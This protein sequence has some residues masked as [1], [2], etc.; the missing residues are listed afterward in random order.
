MGSSSLRVLSPEPGDELGD[1]HSQA[2]AEP[3]AHVYSSPLNLQRALVSQSLSGTS[4]AP[5]AA[6]PVCEGAETT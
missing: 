2:K 5:S 1:P 3:H 4:L 6:Q